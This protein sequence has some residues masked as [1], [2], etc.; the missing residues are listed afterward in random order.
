MVGTIEHLNM[1][2]EVMEAYLP[3][4]FSGAS[5]LYQRLGGEKRNSNPHPQPSQEVTDIIKERLHM[6][7]EFYNFVKQRLFVQWK[8]ITDQKL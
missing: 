6:D 5:R 7:I 4:Y 2:L 3:G 8:R 1:S